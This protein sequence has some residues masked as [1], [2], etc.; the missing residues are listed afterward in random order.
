MQPALLIPWKD[1]VK[2]PSVS[3]DGWRHTTTLI[4][5]DGNEISFRPE[6]Y[7]IIESH[8]KQQKGS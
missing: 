7:Q 4:V 3:M 2:K 1:F 6:V 8:L 5:R